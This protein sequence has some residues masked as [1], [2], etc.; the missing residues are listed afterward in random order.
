M[1]DIYISMGGDT[2]GN[3][4][5]DKECVKLGISREIDNFNKYLRD[6]EE[7]WD[8]RIRLNI[9]EL[10]ILGHGRYHNVNLEN[11]HL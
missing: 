8:V 6:V 3:W 2:L 11:I 1:N 4:M 9:E 7:K 5:M 10:M